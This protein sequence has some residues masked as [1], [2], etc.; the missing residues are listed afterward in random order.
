MNLFIKVLQRSLATFERLAASWEEAII[1]R[2]RE[3]IT[4]LRQPDFWLSL[5]WIVSASSMLFG[6]AWFSVSH[7]DTFLRLQPALC[8]KTLDNARLM[9]IVM[10]AP[11][12]LVFTLVASSEFMT[13]R[14]RRASRGWAGTGYFWGYTALMLL[15]WATLLYAMRC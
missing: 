4:V 13:I 11:F 7:Y 2:M 3:L 8:S 5:V 12:S 10:V 15:S 6:L 9:V 14:K 1:Q